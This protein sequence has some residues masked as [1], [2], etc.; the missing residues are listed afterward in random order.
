MFIRTSDDEVIE[1]DHAHSRVLEGMCD[2]IGTDITSRPVPLAVSSSV[3]C[4]LKK[5]VK[6]TDEDPDEP[7]DC[8][9]SMAH[10]ADYLDMPELLDRTCRR[11]ATLLKGKSPDEI[12][13]MMGVKE[14]TLF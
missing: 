1:F 3:L 8:L 2:E 14:N 11:M 4:M 5:W 10:A 7:W 9:M 13:T 6:V 12:R